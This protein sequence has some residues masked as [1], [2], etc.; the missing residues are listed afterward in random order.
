[1]PSGAKKRR[2]A[3]QK[4]KE[5]QTNNNTNPQGNDDPKSQDERDSDGGDVD[6]PASQDHHNEEHPFREESEDF[7]KRERSASVEGV[8]SDAQGNRVGVED[9]GVVKIEKELDSEQDAESKDVSVEHVKSAKESQVGDDSS[10]SSSSSS[11]DESHTSVKKLKE[12]AHNAF[13]NVKKVILEEIT[14]VS[15]AKKLLEKANGNSIVETVPSD[16]LDEPPVPLSEMAKCVMED[17][18]VESAKVLDVIESVLKENEDKLLPK[19]ND[20][21]VSNSL[22]TSDINGNE[23]KISD[24]HVSETTISV[25]KSKH[26]EASGG[27]VN[28]NEGKMLTPSSAHPSEAGKNAVKARDDEPSESTE[29]QPLVSSVPRVTQRTSFMNCCGLLDLFTGSDR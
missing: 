22:V 28:G 21:G 18:E 3:A 17:A 4:R 27:T 1:M 25:E 14:Q 29:T 5:Q 9:D 6:S 13:S 26:S 16:N 11:D 12:E 10:S 20:V 15:G 24:T 23:S 8:S 7:E 19:S 2:K